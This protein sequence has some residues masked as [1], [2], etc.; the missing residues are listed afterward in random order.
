MITEFVNYLVTE[1]RK[2]ANTVAAYESDVREFAG[3]EKE[4]GIDDIVNS[5]STEVVAYLHEL[6]AQK[7]SASTINR[8][9][10]SIRAFYNYMIDRGVVKENPTAEVKSPKAEQKAIEYLSL[11]EI[12]KLIEAQD[13]TPKGIRDRAILEVLYATG[14]KASELIAMNVDDANYRMGFITCNNDYEHA[15]IVP[16]GRPARAALEKYVFEVRPQLLHGKEDENA[17]F[18]NYQGDR[19]S[20]QGLWKVMKECGKKAELGSGLNPNIIRNSFA[21]HMLQNGA[22]LKSLQELMG[23]EDIAATQIY[24]TAMKTRIKDVYDRAHPRA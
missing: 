13:D 1:K 12:D 23:Y 8:K 9:L 5:T 18:L 11:E 16:L 4:R 14:I 10:S 24:L 7:K 20:R 22:D 6:R 15:R 19:I 21:V 2:A 3:F 17:M